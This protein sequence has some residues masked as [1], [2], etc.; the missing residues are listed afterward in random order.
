MQNLELTNLLQFDEEADGPVGW[1]THFSPSLDL[2][3]THTSHEV[4]RYYYNRPHTPQV[5]QVDPSQK[6]S[7]NFWATPNPMKK[8]SLFPPTPRNI[9][10][11]IFWRRV[12]GGH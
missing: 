1:P 7:L 4:S 3:E 12:Y 10:N 6:K 2:P 8:P 9:K 11:W 5:I